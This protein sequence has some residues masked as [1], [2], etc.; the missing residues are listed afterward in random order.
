[1]IQTSTEKTYSIGVIG[2][3]SNI[4]TVWNGTAG[5]HSARGMSIRGPPNRSQIGPFDRVLNPASPIRSRNTIRRT[6]INTCT[7]KT[8]RQRT[9]RHPKWVSLKLQP[10]R[11]RLAASLPVRTPTR[12]LNI[13]LI[14]FPIQH[15]DYPDKKLQSIWSKEWRLKATFHRRERPLRA[16]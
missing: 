7:V 15:L 9:I 3:C 1:M 6:A 4:S 11:A 12:K 5:V 14:M 13:P 10:M 2:N 8:H 16:K